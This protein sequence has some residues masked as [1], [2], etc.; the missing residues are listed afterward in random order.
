M[1]YSKTTFIAVNKMC[2]GTIMD[3]DWHQGAKKL[4][5]SPALVSAE[6]VTFLVKSCGLDLV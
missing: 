1:L 3:I 6:I 4:F 2:V 5:Y